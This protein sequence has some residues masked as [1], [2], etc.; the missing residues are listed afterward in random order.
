MEGRCLGFVAWWCEGGTCMSNGGFMT[1]KAGPDGQ[2][3]INHFIIALAMI[4]SLGLSTVL[5]NKSRFN[6][7]GR[8]TRLISLTRSIRICVGKHTY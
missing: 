1:A 4:S 5:F 8:N 7:I 3:F 6:L 2:G